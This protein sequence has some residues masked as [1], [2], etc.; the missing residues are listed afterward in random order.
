[1][2]VLTSRLDTKS[3]SFRQ[4]RADMLGLID[5][6]RALEQKVVKEE[7]PF[8]CIE[9]GKLFGVKST[10]EKIVT[11]LEGNHAMFTNSHNANLI[12]MCDDCRVNAQ[13]HADAAPFQSKPRPAVRRTEDYLEDDDA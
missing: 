9:C 1:M 4:N 2:A 7:E 13:F 12:R 11:K 10:I 3:E 5:N 8:A 6:V